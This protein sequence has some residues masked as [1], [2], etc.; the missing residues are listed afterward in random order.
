MDVS[1]VFNSFGE[2]FFFVFVFGFVAII[3]I[4]NP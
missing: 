1:Q 3:I 4:A 2:H